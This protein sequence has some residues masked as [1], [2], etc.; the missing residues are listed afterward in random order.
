MRIVKNLKPSLKEFQ[1]L[2]N[3]EGK[4]IWRR[5]LRCDR[6]EEQHNT[7]QKSQKELKMGVETANKIIR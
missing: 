5:K 2:E 7:Y 4:V 1:H 6:G 3:E